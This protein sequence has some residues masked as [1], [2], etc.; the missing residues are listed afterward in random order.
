MTPVSDAK[1]K[2]VKCRMWAGLIGLSLASTPAPF[3]TAVRAD[4]STAGQ[5]METPNSTEPAQQPYE[6]EWTQLAPTTTEAV[7]A[8]VGGQI[9]LLS[10]LQKAVIVASRGSASLSATGQIQGIGI[11]PEEVAD[12]YEKLIDQSVLD[13]KVKELGI[14]VT[15]DELDDEID[16]FL[17]DRKI[18]QETFIQM[19]QREG[20]TEASHRNEFKRQLESQRFIGRVIRPLVSVTDEEVRSFFLSNKP[21]APKPSNDPSAGRGQDKYILRSLLINARST[22]PQ[23]K[24]KLN[25]I[26]KGLASGSAFKDMVKTYSEASDAQITEG[27]LDPRPLSALPTELRVVLQSSEPGTIIGPI[28]IGSSTF[29]FEFVSKE[30]AA[31]S[32]GTSEVNLDEWRQRLL[33]TKFAERLNSYLK[34]ERNKVR[35]VKRPMVFK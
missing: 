8:N 7:I 27:L 6:H 25:S 29:Y 34:A 19:L 23:A 4:D 30:V 17:Q 11:S 2:K 3:A 26:A 18:S 33:E 1:G 21:P 9:L 28:E 15:E 24:L 22:D 14:E 10:D 12:L 5:A 35:V 20:E 13:I 32:K 31:Q 16:R